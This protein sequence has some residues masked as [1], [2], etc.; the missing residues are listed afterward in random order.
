MASTRQSREV[1]KWAAARRA[2]LRLKQT[3]ERIDYEEDVILPEV[4]AM[5]SGKVKLQIEAGADDAAQSIISIVV[6]DEEETEEEDKDV[7]DLP[8]ED[9]GDGEGDD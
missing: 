4:E 8:P 5:L 7:V 1:K 9:W 2:Q 3:F 6:A